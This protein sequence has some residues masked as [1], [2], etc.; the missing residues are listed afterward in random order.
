MTVLFSILSEAH[1]EKYLIRPIKPEDYEVSAKIYNSNPHFLLAHLGLDFV[2]KDFISEE[3]IHMAQAGF[4]S[5]VVIDRENQT[6]C[7]VLDYA[8]GGEVYLSLLMLASEVQRQG[9]GREIYS[10]FERTIAAQGAREIRIDVV[11]EFPSSAA[12]FWKKLGFRECGEVTLQWGEKRSN[13][14]IMRKKIPVLDTSP[15]K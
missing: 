9:A 6:V 5:C 13:A 11:K 3:T 10:L 15:L 4:H 7:G 14:V 1:M 12:L 8:E 2:E